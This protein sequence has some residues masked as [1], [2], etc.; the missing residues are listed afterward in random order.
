MRLAANK[1]G[2]DEQ[3][4][5]LQVA[6]RLAQQ[7]IVRPGTVHDLKELLSILNRAIH[8]IPLAEGSSEWALAYGNLLLNEIETQS[9][10]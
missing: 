7:R 5:L 10:F 4:N 6:E 1:P 2:F 8:G 3:R 9:P